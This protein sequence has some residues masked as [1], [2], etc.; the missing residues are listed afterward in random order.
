MYF[1]GTYELV[2]ERSIL[3]IQNAWNAAGPYRWRAFDNEQYGPYIVAREPSENLKIRLLGERPNYSLE[4]DADVPAKRLD[5]ARA[6]VFST[7]LDR[8]L[9]LIGAKRPQ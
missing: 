3:E 6:L 8:L 4:I 5:A 2:C 7:M 9:P 1:G